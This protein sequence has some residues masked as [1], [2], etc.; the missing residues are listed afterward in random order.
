MA[1]SVS[2][3]RVPCARM[4]RS[5]VIFTVAIFLAT[6]AV[7]QISELISLPY[8]S[9]RNTVRVN[10]DDQPLP[11]S[12]LMQMWAAQKY[13]LLKPPP[14]FSE[15]QQNDAED[16]IAE[17]QQ[18]QE[19]ENKQEQQ[20]Q[21]LEDWAHKD[22]D[23]AADPAAEAGKEDDESLPLVP[24][25]L[26]AE[27][28]RYPPFNL[29]EDT[30][31]QFFTSA[32]QLQCDGRLLF[33]YLNGHLKLNTTL[34]AKG[35]PFD[36]CEFTP[37]MWK[38]DRSFIY[39]EP[40][41]SRQHPFEDVPTKDQD[42]FHVRCFGATANNEETESKAD[43]IYEQFLAQISPRVEVIKRA[44]EI[45]EALGKKPSSE[46]QPRQMNV[47]IFAIESL[48]HMSAMRLL[49]RTYAYLRQNMHAVILN[50]FNT[51]GDST[52]GTLIPLLTG[53]VK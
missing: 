49:P 39:G 21:P 29:N 15:K 27:A 1:R 25:E 28:C 7:L 24:K 43:A 33:D 37:I 45:L 47:L 40:V 51:V 19:E 14:N 16:A 8:I 23:D 36:H 41:I 30:I 3:R 6:V 5:S 35:D 20:E 31:G 17:A 44:D 50:G 12:S 2:W 9:A 11:E 38:D 52:T 46:Q 42:F 48:S 53:K 4:K 34:Y 10:D 22:A 13:A 18:Q 32:P 26:E